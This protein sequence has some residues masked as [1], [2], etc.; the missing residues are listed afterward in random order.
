[1]PSTRQFCPI[2]LLALAPWWVGRPASEPPGGDPQTE[3]QSA[4]REET[5]HGQDPPAA[6]KRQRVVVWPER[7][8][9]V[10]GY[11]ELEDDDVLVV[12]QRTGQVTSFTKSRVLQ[13][14]R[15]VEPEPDQEGVVRLRNGQAVQGV[16]VEDGF[17]EVVAVV[18]GI[19]MRFS[20]QDVDRVTLTP[21]FDQLY[22]EYKAS[23][24]PKPSS[25]HL[26]LCRWLME[27]HRYDLAKVELA[28]IMK[29][30]PTLSEPIRL[31]KIVDAQLA[32]DTDRLAS[33]N[34]RPTDVPTDD[35]DS[36]PVILADILPDR[37]L[38]H[39]EVNLVR[40]YEID[41]A[42]PPR[43]AVQPD[44]IRSMLEKYGSSNV[45]PRN[46]DQR[47]ALFRAEDIQ[48]VRL[49]FDL[50][51]RELYP[52]IEVLSEPRALNLFHRRVHNSWLMNNCATS[53]CHGGPYAGRLFLHRE[54]SRDERV[55]YTNLL[56]L[57]R[58]ELDPQWPL[59]N[60]DSP[61]DSLLIQ[62]ALPRE[63]ARRPHPDIRGWRP[64]FNRNNERLLRSTIEWIESMMQPR[65][66][67]PI[68]YEPPVMGA[69]REPAEDQ[70]DR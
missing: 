69:P 38:S 68:D 6:P 48:I 27:Q 56:I 16:I 65:P 67:Y 51:A 12:R 22:A 41:F 8:Q 40:V 60:Y 42:D 19:R 32:M 63:V 64:V 23:L 11:L 44:T 49:L 57:E 14:V 10:A 61:A 20:R 34:D 15:L 66:A 59:I 58:L 18:Q 3:E 39:S 70:T 35:R 62:A 26:E 50:K 25:R 13:V 46:A 53:R 43:V 21:S 7:N 17:D 54:N 5:S 33:R 29:E 37:I 28:A 24:G 36:G 47:T 30:D 31:M 52:E 2:L 45:I 9:P 4:D 55:R 1:M